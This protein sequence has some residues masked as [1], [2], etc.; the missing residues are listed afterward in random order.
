MRR[1]AT[2]AMA[3]VLGLPA[4]LHAERTVPANFD[5]NLSRAAGIEGNAGSDFGEAINYY[6]GETTFY[7]QGPSVPGNNDLPLMRPRMF[8]GYDDG[9]NY[10]FKWVS[11]GPYLS[12]TYSKETG[13]V[14]DADGADRFKRCSRPN[15]S[16]SAPIVESTSGKAGIWEPEEYWKGITLNIDGKSM[17]LNAVWDG[18]SMPSMPTTG[19]P[20]RW[21]TNNGW[22]FSCI[23]L[24]SGEEGFV[25]VTP[26]GERY[27]FDRVSQSFPYPQLK[28]YNDLGDTR[29]DVAEVRITATRHEDR[30]GN[31]VEGGATSD[32]RAVTS[33]SNGTRTVYSSAG[34]QWIYDRDGQ[35]LTITYPDLSQWKLEVDNGI[36]RN[37][38]SYQGCDGGVHLGARYSGSA[39]V[40]ITLRSGAKGTFRFEPRNRGYS[41][42]QY[43]CMDDFHNGER[44]AVQNLIQ[45][46]ALVSKTV[47]GPGLSTMTT[48]FD[49]GA[50]NDCFVGFSVRGNECTSSSPRTRTVSVT[51]PGYS[52]ARYTFG[53]RAEVD[54]GLLLKLEIGAGPDS[55]RR[56][57]TYKYQQF[58]PIG[59]PVGISEQ[60]P[61]HWAKYRV[62]ESERVVTDASGASFA[63]RVLEFDSLARPLRTRRWNSSGFD[64]TETVAYHDNLAR[65][66]L[67]QP[68]RLTVN[69]VVVSETSYSSYAQPLTY[70]SF[71]KLQWT[72]THDV[73][74][75][76][77]MGTVKTVKDGNNNVTTLSNWKRG[78]P[79]S[80]AHADGTTQS[81][82]VND[83]G[84]IT[85]VT[86]ENGFATNYAYDPMG[87][88]SKITY[89]AGDSTA[90]NATTFVFEQRAGSAYGL[91]GGH[92]RQ[93]IST[94]NGRKLT[95]FDALWRPVLVQ[96]YDTADAAATNR[97]TRYAYDHD[98]RTT[99]TSY[100]VPSVS[101]LSAVTQGVHTSYDALG[102]TTSVRQNSE[103]GDLVSAYSYLSNDDGYYTRVTDPKGNQTRTWF[104]AFDEPSYDTPISIW[105]PE[106]A[107][108]HITRDVFG[109]PTRIRRSNSSSA[110]GGTT[111]VNRSYSYNANHELCRMVEPETGAT[112]MGYDGAGN[113]AWSAGGLPISTACHATGDTAAISA[114]RAL[115]SYDERNRITFLSFPDNRG[116]TAHTYTPDG[117]PRTIEANNGGGN[118]VTTAYSYN[119]RRLLTSERM[120]WGTIAWTLGTGYNANGHV[121]S[122]S[123]PAEGAVSYAPN[124]LG[125]PTRVGNVVTGV[126][127]HPN[128]T[129]KQ[130]AYDNGIVHT[131]TQNDRGLP[132]TRMDA[133]EDTRFL[134]DQYDYDPNGNVAAITDGATGRNQRGNRDMEYDGL[135]R[136]TRTTSAMFGTATYAYDVLDNLTRTK[137]SGGNAARDHHYCYDGSWRLASIRNGSCSG[138][139]VTALGY[140][141][142][143]NLS[144][145][146]GVNFGF[147]YGNRLRSTSAGNTTYVYDGLGRR[148]R[149]I[150]GS[151]RYSLYSQA[152]QLM[153]TSDRRKELDTVYLYLGDR[154]VAQVDRSRVPP[155]G[156]PTLSVPATNN[157]SSFTASWTAVATAERYELEQRKGGGAWG[158][159]YSG[160]SL[161]TVISGLSN[162]SYEHRIRACNAAGCAGYSDIESTAVA[163]LPGGAPVVTAPV[164]DNDGAFAVSWTAVAGAAS[165]RLEQRKDGGAWSEIYS[166]TALSKAITGLNN[167]SYDYRA[168]ACNE[169][170]CAGFSP[171][172][173]TTVTFPPSGGAPT[174][175]APAI[176]SD[177]TFTVS[178]TS[179]SGATEYRLKQSKDGGS[180]TTVYTGPGFSKM[181]LGLSVGTWDY[182]VRACNVGGCTAYSNIATTEV[183]F[184]PSGAPT[185]TAPATDNNGAFTVSWNSVTTATS[186]ILQQ[187]R[188]GGSWGEIYS[189]ATRSKAVSGL[190]N[191]N[192][193][194][195]VQACNAGGCG[196]FSGIKTTVVTH[197]PGGAP[198]VTAPATDNNG[199]F[200]ISWTGVSGATSYDLWQR[201]DGSGVEDPWQLVYSGASLSKAMSGLANGRYEYQAKAC[202]TGGC[203]SGSA[204]KV[205]VV[206]HPPG[207]APTVT[208]PG[209]NSN[210]AFTVSWTSV[211]TSTSYRLEQSRNSGSWTEIYSG[212][213]RSKAVSGLG[214]GSYA[215]R[216]RACNAGGCGGYSGIKTTLVTFPP[217]GVPTLN[218]PG[219]VNSYLQTSYSVSWSTVATATRYELQRHPGSGSWSVAYNAGG[220]SSTFASV[221]GFWSYR[222][223]ACNAG[224]CGSFSS[225]KTVSVENMGGCRPGEPTCQDPLSVPETG[226]QL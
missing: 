67:G 119:R 180:Y 85:R 113:L 45:G 164:H 6:S 24:P 99:F 194:Y 177:G 185:L 123:Y 224:G 141:E 71:G 77:Q 190:N 142:Q 162:G 53:N 23:T 111:V 154:L 215:Y 120:E 144:S 216:A 28:K 64:R 90:W 69:G 73:T 103:L 1:L 98:G 105:H 109:K 114:R 36:I 223:R 27:R 12:G 168:Q 56:T 161:S 183:V 29:L 188:N 55:I 15:A 42:T 115:R 222:I 143:G 157:T 60:A 11:A 30:F 130:F 125:Q 197:P 172:A 198:T 35:N 173:T 3:M 149:D 221:V 50:P 132:E 225:V 21:S 65:W 131:L 209:S 217:S 107:Y 181:M 187:R 33:E 186:Y 19:G 226:E 195:R 126:T 58:D 16:A 134:Q 179:R 7:V 124:A 137:L 218:A 63:R 155:S 184:P 112:L 214:N 2:V 79:Q 128:G 139:T 207:S 204:I 87:R 46:I 166:G 163:L 52:F 140:D 151:S 160:P 104:Q 14:T 4:S 76:G 82:V 174:L 121:S 212:A 74:I 201:K 97:F 191:G 110:T 83:A 145:R 18:V 127:Y 170:G 101:S 70:R 169:V 48:L 26:E 199:A 178:W 106:G 203:G 32:G 100:P 202:N 147:D 39:T 78:V 94:G 116:N 102:R 86:D 20:Y 182:Q 80:I 146:G 171:I 89:P 49:Y 138:S 219:H 210:G 8:Q 66:V 54:D 93:V 108:T 136:L 148:V 208:A 193:D 96:E 25:G 34:R 118:V 13:W 92:W 213:S 9:R 84:W 51:R 43:R 38:H 61:Q 135:D 31:W 88:L 153:F 40:T 22:F 150:T 211:S 156:V 57:E 44:L 91:S 196:A 5:T 167:G 205:T 122:H 47:S 152:G 72:R 17:H 10:S 189:G 175:T 95:Y 117:L 75:A 200:T 129:P 41:D 133:Y 158:Q 81:A 68:S 37:D 159:V 165:Y 192:Y 220:T 62:E 59:V 206:T 176:D